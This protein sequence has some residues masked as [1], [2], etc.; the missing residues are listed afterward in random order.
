[1]YSVYDTPKGWVA[2]FGHSGIKACSRLLQNF[3]SVP[4]PSSPPGAKASTECPSLA[5]T[6]HLAQEQPTPA[7]RSAAANR[8]KQDLSLL[9]FTLINAPEPCS[10]A[11]LGQPI[12]Q[13]RDQPNRV[14][15]PHRG[16]HGRP[17]IPH[18]R[19]A[20]PSK[21]PSRP[22][23]PG[24]HQNLIHTCQRTINTR[25]A[26]IASRHTAITQ[27]N[28]SDLYDPIPRQQWTHSALASPNQ[29]RRS[30]SP[31]QLVAVIGITPP[32]S[33]GGDRDHSTKVVEVIGIEPTTPC[34]Q[35]RCS[36]N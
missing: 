17:T 6:I 2:P 29:R 28:G 35:S 18:S 16:S 20:Q 26:S 3:R 21:T 13:P 25:P 1:M 36:P 34:L 30:G 32:S 4:R 23:R 19:I 33:G 5:Q 9:S 22:A 27:L 10:A 15:H 7:P 14:R 31:H 24:A 8:P 12:P 11:M